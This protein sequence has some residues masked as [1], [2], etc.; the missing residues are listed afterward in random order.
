MTISPEELAKIARLA[1]LNV[2]PESAPQLTQEVSAIM[3][4]VEQLRAV[5]TSQIA[6][7]FHPFTLHQRL[8]TD[9]VTEEE[10]LAELAAIAP[11]FEDN[12]YLV[13]QV[14]D[15]GK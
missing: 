15:T 8:R 1:Y 5:D 9:E 7:L 4:F 14:I 13:P 2:E 11:H 12:L 6:P 10:C 3:D